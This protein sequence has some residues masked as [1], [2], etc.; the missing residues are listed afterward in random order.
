MENKELHV[1]FVKDVTVRVEVRD[2][3]IIGVDGSEVRHDISGDHRA[4]LVEA[5]LGQVFPALGPGQ[6]VAKAR[7]P[8]AVAA[9]EEEDGTGGDE[10]QYL[11]VKEA[12]GRFKLPKYAIYGWV[13]DGR[14]K[15]P[16]VAPKKEKYGRLRIDAALFENW[17][18]EEAKKKRT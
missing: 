6:D 3:M 17:L 16:V 11:S 5:L 8:K 13:K 18:A 1:R 4:A 14:L 12:T 15:P 10:A 7:K 9:D 2:S